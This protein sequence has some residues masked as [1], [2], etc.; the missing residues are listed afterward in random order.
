MADLSRRHKVNRSTSNVISVTGGK[1]TTYR[2]MA[3]DTVDAVCEV[4]GKQLKSTTKRLP[5]IGAEGYMLPADRAA[6]HLANRYGSGAAEVAAL[7]K[8]QTGLDEP[9]V[10]G[11]PYIKAEAVHAARAEMCMTLDDVLSRRTRARLFDRPAAV[12][13]ADDVARL[14]APE[15]GWDDAEVQRQVAEFRKLCASEQTAAVTSESDLL[16]VNR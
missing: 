10:P 4:L 8:A 14:I 2:E 7:S 5:L 16:G 6:A 11:L 13:A 1:L 3:E 12:A 15:M 9:L